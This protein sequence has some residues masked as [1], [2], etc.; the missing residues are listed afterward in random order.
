MLRYRISNNRPDSQD[1]WMEVDNVDCMLT[2][3]LLATM[4]NVG[5]AYLQLTR[6]RRDQ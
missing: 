1:G 3:S 5:Q 2:N 6:Q 4:Y